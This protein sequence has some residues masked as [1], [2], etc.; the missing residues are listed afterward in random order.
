[1][2]LRPNHETLVG[3]DFEV[4]LCP[5]CGNW[6]LTYVAKSGVIGCHACGIHPDLVDEPSPGF[7]AVLEAA[8]PP[9][10]SEPRVAPWKRVG[11]E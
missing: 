10:A 8:L 6:D 11:G 3:C 4:L 2:A 7:M 5:D 9:Q 1:M